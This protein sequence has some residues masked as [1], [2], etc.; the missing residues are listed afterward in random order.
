MTANGWGE[1]R[2]TI[3][4]EGPAAPLLSLKLNAVD[5]RGYGLFVNVGICPCIQPTHTW[6]IVIKIVEDSLHTPDSRKNF[7]IPSNCKPELTT[8]YLAYYLTIPSVRTFW[9][10]LQSYLFPQVCRCYY[11]NTTR[12]VV[13]SSTTGMLVDRNL[14]VDVYK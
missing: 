13:V 1:K 10:F 14:Y 11:Y 5:N 2:L 12:V 7:Q 4:R 9:P 6:N 8:I 3:G